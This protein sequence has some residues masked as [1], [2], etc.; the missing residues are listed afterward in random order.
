MTISIV[1]NV[2][3]VLLNIITAYFINSKISRL[4]KSEIK[5]SRYNQL[6]VEA[7]KSI[8]NKLVDF[9][10]SNT[11]LFYS[12]L[13]VIEEDHYRAMISEWHK[14]IHD[15]VYI[16][17]KERIFM[18]EVLKT[19]YNQTIKNFELVKNILIDERDEI[20]DVLEP[21]INSD[22]T[23]HEVV[24]NIISR[25]LDAMKNQ[26]EFIESEKNIKE[27]RQEIEN[28]VSKMN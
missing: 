27:L 19:K 28:F 21:Y 2:F 23:S 9:H 12:R 5:F 26:K 18:P 4:K 1:A 13:E 20:S 11:K 14:H 3:V 15:F 8:Y 22:Y 10:Y 24:S 6:Q 25:R 7:L 17:N 16:V